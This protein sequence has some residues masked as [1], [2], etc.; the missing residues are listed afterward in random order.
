MAHPYYKTTRLVLLPCMAL[1]LLTA[2]GKSDSSSSSH[3]QEREEE[4][5]FRQSGDVYRAVLTPLNKQLSGSPSGIVEVRIVNGEI[6]IE[7]AMTDTPAGVKHLQAIH[8]RGKCPD[9]THDLNQDGVI[10][11]EEAL[12]QTGKMLIPLDDDLKTQ[13]SGITFGPVSNEWGNYVYQRS[14][15]QDQLLSDLHA[16]ETPA[17]EYLAK[18]PKDEQLNLINRSVVIYGI[19]AGETTN[20]QISFNGHTPEESLPIACGKFEKI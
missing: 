5:K 1:L 13:N 2:C 11:I 20:S 7:S 4:R 18:L 6:I 16:G 12:S 19:A 14:T 3:A 17:H 15:F 8:E 9:V 10:D